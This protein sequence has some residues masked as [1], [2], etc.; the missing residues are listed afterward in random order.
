M[1]YLQ[2]VESVVGILVALLGAAWGMNKYYLKKEAIDP[3]KKHKRHTDARFEDVGHFLERIDAKQEERYREDKEERAKDELE[4]Q[5]WLEQFQQIALTIQASAQ[6]ISFLEKAIKS[7]QE[8]I[9]DLK[10]W[11]RDLSERVV[12][13]EQK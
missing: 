8:E 9:R 4:R 3:L 5:K 1:E 2:G 7:N 12:K 6:N 11:H 10:K 13:L